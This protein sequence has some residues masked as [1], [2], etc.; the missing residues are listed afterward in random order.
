MS[1]RI[2]ALW[3]ALGFSRGAK[4]KNWTVCHIWGIDDP[5][6]RKHN[7]IVQDPRFYSCVGN[8]VALPT[9][10]K[11]FTDSIPEIK[12]MLRICAYYLYGWLCE[13]DSV[14]EQAELITSG[15]VPKGYPAT[16]PKKLG[17]PPPPGVVE[18][19]AT[20]QRF[21][22]K[23]KAEIQRELKA[24]GCFYPRD[25]VPEVLR[26]LEYRPRSLIPFLP[27]TT[28]TP[29]TPVRAVRSERRTFPVRTI[30]ASRH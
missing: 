14:K 9:P 22:D 20:V 11:A 23:R 17:D 19:S 26:F 27:R 7:A 24:A 21:V 6:F 13:H 18:F 10:L 15:L 12:L 25:K 5:A 8:M 16:W 4:P 3:Q 28:N 1:E 2:G 30:A 29:A